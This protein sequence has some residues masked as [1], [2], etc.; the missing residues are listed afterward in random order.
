MQNFEE[1]EKKVQEISLG[2]DNSSQD[3]DI[4]LGKVKDIWQE[5]VKDKDKLENILLALKNN[6]ELSVKDILSIDDLTIADIELIFTLTYPFKHLF[7]QQNSKKIPLLKGK[8]IINLFMEESTRTRTSFELAA[9]HLG[10]DAVNIN[11][12]SSSMA[13]KGEALND[14]VR[15]INAMMADIIIFRHSKSGSAQMIA[16]EIK[17]PVINAGDGIHEHPT[18]ALLDAYT[19]WERFGSIKDKI[20]LVVGDI[21]HS[22]VAGSLFRIINKLGGKLRLCAPTTLIPYAAEDIFKTEIFTE[23][24]EA[25]KDADVVYA[26]RPQRERAMESYIPTIREYSKR[27]CINSERL[28]FAKST[29]I[30]MHAG[31]INRE[32][33]IRTEV[34]ENQQS[35]VEEQ[36]T[37]GFALRMT[38]LWLMGNKRAQKS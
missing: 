17:A 9:K 30:V 26:L 15:T 36:V 14:T 21:K 33:D 8:S 24:E 35:V 10:A 4:T 5:S 23:I 11:K 16:H 12:S 28:K 31:P 38:L 34:M 19:I 37:N 32:I 7:I 13:K 20:V 18:Q 3:F 29:A 6:Q 22:R 1:V 27:Y 25:I 2:A